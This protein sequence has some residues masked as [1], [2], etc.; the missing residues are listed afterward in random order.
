[1]VV[2]MLS[3]ILITS[4]GETFISVDNQYDDK[5]EALKMFTERANMLKFA[6]NVKAIMKEDY[7][8]QHGWGVIKVE[9]NNGN[10]VELTMMEMHAI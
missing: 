9:L 8:P 10:I 2:Y 1:M 4:R 5:G 6:K 7:N 3:E